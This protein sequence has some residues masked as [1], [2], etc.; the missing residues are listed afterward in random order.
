MQQNCETYGWVHL[1]AG[2]LLRAER[3]DP[4][5]KHGELINEYIREGKIVPV[6][7]TLLSSARP[8]KALQQPTSW[9][10][11]PSVGGQPE[12]REDNMTTCTDVVSLLSRDF[13]KSHGATDHAAVAGD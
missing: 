3:K 8:W 13:R 12:G 5:S 10:T 11:A 7:I 4:S 1:S 6:E 9:S 2:D